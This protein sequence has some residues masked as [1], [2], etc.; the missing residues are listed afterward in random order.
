MFFK[1]FDLKYGFGNEKVHPCLSILDSLP[2]LLATIPT[3]THKWLVQHHC[4]TSNVYEK[5]ARLLLDP[6]CGVKDINF[7]LWWHPFLELT[8]CWLW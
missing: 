4:S 1:D 8:V 6:N 7:H 2:F 3:T 5:K